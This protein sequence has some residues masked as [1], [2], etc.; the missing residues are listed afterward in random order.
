MQINT[1]FIKHGII[2]RVLAITDSKALII[3]C[4]ESKMPYWENIEFLDAYDTV[5][6]S[7][8]LE[9]ANIVFPPYDSLPQNLVG[10][11]HK[12]YGIISLIIPHIKSDA[13]RNSAI[14]ILNH[15]S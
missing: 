13:E 8:L 12:K 11:M 6:E 5:T 10:H 7:E 9:T 2:F 3:N 14:V 1:L 15:D 4:F